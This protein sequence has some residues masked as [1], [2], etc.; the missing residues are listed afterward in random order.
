MV[1]GNE[2]C[3]FS[4]IIESRAPVSIIYEDEMVIGCMDI[5]SVNQD[6]ALV[7]S[8]VHVPQLTDLRPNIC[9]HMFEVA[10]N[11]SEA[12]RAS[13]LRCEGINLLLADGEAAG[14]KIS[15]VH[16]H[17]IPRFEGEGFGF[18]FNEDYFNLP[19]R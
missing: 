5:Q 18:R 17:V 19:E 15:H 10:M 14:Q 6:H 4:K 1:S 11:F 16:L 12:M 3:I 2:D 7:F 9:A 8:K 13:D